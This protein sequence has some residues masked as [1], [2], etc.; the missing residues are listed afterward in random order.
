MEPTNELAGYTVIQVAQIV[1][2]IISNEPFHTLLTNAPDLLVHV[3]NYKNLTQ[4]RDRPAHITVYKAALLD[5]DQETAE[6]VSLKLLL[7][8]HAQRARHNDLKQKDD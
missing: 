2:A 1:A 3:P 8:E 5:P 6:K 7:D 4:I